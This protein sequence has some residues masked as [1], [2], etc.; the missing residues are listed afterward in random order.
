MPARHGWWEQLRSI[1][2]LLVAKSKRM[3]SAMAERLPILG[4]GGF[5]GLHFSCPIAFPE[6]NASGPIVKSL[7][8]LPWRPDEE[9]CYLDWSEISAFVSVEP[10]DQISVLK[11][12]SSFTSEQAPAIWVPIIC[13]SVSQIPLIAAAGEATQ[14]TQQVEEEAGSYRLCQ[15]ELY[16]K[17]LLSWR[18]FPVPHE[19]LCM[20]QIR[21]RAHLLAS[22]LKKMS[23]ELRAEEGFMVGED[24]GERRKGHGMTQTLC[25]RC[26]AHWDLL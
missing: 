3:Q 9:V 7:R 2:N 17:T 12:C 26:F 6:G 18:C 5:L 1:L 15:A 14:K 8:P 10:S 20:S 11:A 16:F 23:K 22:L 13:G 25:S 19:S 4:R 24:W 21:L